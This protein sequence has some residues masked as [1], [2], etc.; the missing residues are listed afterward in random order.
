M[1]SGCSGSGGPRENDD[2]HVQFDG[3]HSTRNDEQLDDANA[4]RRHQRNT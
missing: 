1:S 2:R 4:E 3:D